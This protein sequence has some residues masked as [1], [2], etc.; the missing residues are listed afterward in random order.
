MAKMDR[1]ILEELIRFNT[2]NH[3]ADNLNESMGGIA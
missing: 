3:N 1:K 2:L